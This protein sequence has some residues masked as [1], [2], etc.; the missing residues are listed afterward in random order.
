MDFFFFLEEPYGLSHPV[1]NQQTHKP[2]KERYLLD[3]N[4]C[5]MF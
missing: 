3:F 1:E 2:T 5:K 4:S